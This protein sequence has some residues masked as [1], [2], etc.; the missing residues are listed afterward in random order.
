[1]LKTLTLEAALAKAGGIFPPVPA[2]VQ[3]ILDDVRARGS[4][5]VTAWARKLDAFQGDTFEVPRA[6]L[7]AAPGLLEPGLRSHLEAAIRRVA[8]FARAQKA[9]FRDFSL[10]QDGMVLGQ[11]VLPVRRAACYA[12]G[13]RYP[14]PS[15]VLMGVVPAKVA[16]VEEVIVLSPRLHPVTLAAAAL[17]GADRV[18]DLG[19]VQGVAAAAWGLAGVPRVDLVVGPG[20]R[21]VTGAKRLLY[22]D[23]GI[24]FP[25]GPSELLVIA[26]RGAHPAWIAADLLAQA[27]HDPDAVPALAVFDPE[28]I[29]QVNAE[30]ALQLAAL[31]P[32]TPARE[33]L[34]NG[35]AVFLTRDAD[36]VA[37]ADALAPEHLELQG[38][39]AEA[40]EGRFHN[41]G[42]L[43]LGEDAAE[44]FGDYGSGTN[45]ILPTSGAARFTGGVSVAT[46]LKILT[47]QRTLPEG[48]APLVA[49]AAAI[50]R[51][52]G[53]AGHEASA[54]MRAEG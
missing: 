44:V 36:A 27:E 52:E 37:L 8:G 39:R 53:L 47:W 18:F 30:L 7:E 32:G 46:F 22:G 28:L 19:G 3:T 24:D 38:P 49:Q 20:N 4:E 14:L 1:M 25:A 5:A 29:P 54:L 48:R 16:G 11:R 6:R 42:S 34:A 21:Y 40:L 50:A 23:V 45:H 43:F 13:G 26:D 10:E 41:Y 33:S 2:V 15:S 12:P 35:F 31:P 9:T 51:A 17:A